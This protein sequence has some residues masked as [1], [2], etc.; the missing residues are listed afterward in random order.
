MNPSRLPRVTDF[1]PDITHGYITS[2][3]RQ[4]NLLVF[5]TQSDKPTA[6][7]LQSP[8]FVFEY[9]IS[10]SGS[11]F[12]SLINRSETFDYFPHLKNL[13]EENH[14]VFYRILASAFIPGPKPEDQR[15]LVRSWFASK[16][17]YDPKVIVEARLFANH[18][19]DTITRFPPEK[20][21]SDIDHL[22]SLTYLE[23]DDADHQEKFLISSQGFWT[24]IKMDREAALINFPSKITG[25][26][27]NQ[28]MLTNSLFGCPESP[29]FTGDIDAITD[30]EAGITL[31]KNQ[32]YWT[33]ESFGPET[34][35]S[36]PRL[37]SDNWNSFVGFLDAAAN[38]AVGGERRVLFFRD[39]KVHYCHVTG[40]CYRTFFISYAFP[41]MTTVDAAFVDDKTNQIYLIKG[42]IVIAYESI[43]EGYPAKQTLGPKSVFEEWDNIPD[44]VQDA[45][46]TK[47]KI[48]FFS[49]G[50]AL[51][52][53]GT[54]DPVFAPFNMFSCNTDLT[55]E[56]GWEMLSIKGREDI[57]ALRRFNRPVLMQRTA[58]DMGEE[59][60]LDNHS[61][62]VT[63]KQVFM[64]VFF[65][66]C[67]FSIFLL[68]FMIDKKVKQRNRKEDRTSFALDESRY[69]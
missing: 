21:S 62:S 68:I 34:Q 45:Y 65:M 2:G 47:G 56:S 23:H 30:T 44:N 36:K 8:H 6:N 58:E 66:A 40:D 5:T 13:Q 31:F 32:Y 24:R 60:L 33:L 67:V 61:S 37:I 57:E 15:I 48:L 46:W 39:R 16:N 7:N 22:D 12:F 11:G 4:G 14:W 25:S 26:L 63:S 27:R 20:N 29:C 49:Q 3:Y 53:N 69:Q 18:T 50:F 55:R 54:S 51:T 1:F 35:L 19:V 9:E 59:P 17:P 28:V 38:V 52:A 42:E 41:G 64:W 43:V 10:E